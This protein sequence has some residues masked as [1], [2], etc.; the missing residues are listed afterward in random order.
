MWSVLNSSMRTL[1]LRQKFT[2]DAIRSLHT[3]AVCEAARKGTREKARKKKVKVEVKKVGFIPHN[4]RDN[5]LNLQRENKHVDDSWKQ[6]STDNC[7]VGKYYR[8][9]VYSVADAIQCHRETHHPSMYNEPNAPLIAHVEMNMKGEKATRFVDNFQRMAMMPHKFDHGEERRILVFTKGNDE[10][11]EARQAGATLVGGVELI[12]DITNG[13]LL[14]TDYQYVIAHP[15]ILPELV[16]LRGLMKRK[17]PNPKSE[18]LGTNLAEMIQRFADGV[19]YMANKDEHQQDFGLITTTIGTL[20]MD[21]KH[22]EDNLCSLLKDIN[23]VRPKR[24]GRF[25][26]RVLLKSPPSREQL[27]IDAFLYVPEMFVKSSGGSQQ[28]SVKN[29]KVE[30]DDDDEVEKKQAEAAVN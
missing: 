28:K 12:K 18:T 10:I 16:A 26:T 6:I 23:S 22:L 30:K 1:V 2:I 19:S 15:N 13:E 20:N 21:A 29:T 27:K 4:E 14:L 7:Y 25:I 8:W 5:K 24:E 11:A 3:T 9:P 17:F